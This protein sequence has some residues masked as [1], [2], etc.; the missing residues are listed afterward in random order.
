VDWNHLADDTVD[1]PLCEAFRSRQDP[2]LPHRSAGH[3]PTA[4]TPVLVPQRIS[5]EKVEE[6]RIKIE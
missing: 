6:R 3:L 4:P 2:V 1:A 5:T